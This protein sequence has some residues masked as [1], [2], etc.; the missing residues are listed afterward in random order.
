M[1]FETASPRAMCWLGLGAE[2]GADVEEKEGTRKK[3]V[4]VRRRE[5][6]NVEMGVENEERGNGC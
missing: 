6:F 5:S 1:R 4:V 3:K 2:G